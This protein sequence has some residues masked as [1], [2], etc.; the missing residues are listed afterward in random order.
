MLYMLTPWRTVET[1]LPYEVACYLKLG[2]KLL[3]RLP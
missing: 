2:W 1:V 3:R